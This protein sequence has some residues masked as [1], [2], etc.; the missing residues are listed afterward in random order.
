M[1]L[2]ALGVAFLLAAGAVQAQ[3][4]KGVSANG[5]GTAVGGTTNISITGGQGVGNNLFHSFT[6]FDLETGQSATFF[7]N[8]STANIIARVTGGPSWIDGT[9][10]TSA[11]PATSLW[12]LNPAG[13]AF[14]QN[15][16]LDVTGSFHASSA[17]AL[18][19]GASGQFDMASAPAGTLTV[20]PTA[21][22]FLSPPAPITVSG[23]QLTVPAGKHI[24][25]VGGDIT[26]NG[27]TLHVPA[28]QINVA[29]LA[30][31][32]EVTVGSGSMGAT[33][34]SS[35]GQ[36]TLA[37]SNLNTWDGSDPTLPG[38]NAG[39]IF[40]RGG[41]L[42]MDQAIVS[43]AHTAAG[44]GGDI[45]IVL[46]GDFSMS[47][48]SQINA[49]S[50]GSGNAGNITL[51]AGNVV[52]SGDQTR[53]DNSAVDQLGSSGGRAGQTIIEASGDMTL[54]GGA[55][56]TSVTFST[57][58]AGGDM[59]ITARNLT[60]S[61][62]LSMI[63]VATFGDGAGG[64][65]I[66]NVDSLRVAD[67]G[68]IA[69]ASAPHPT[70]GPAFGNAGSIDITAAHSVALT[71]GG[72]ITTFATD[73]G[74]G[75]ITIRATDLVSL[76]HSMITT[77][78]ADGTGNGG[79]ISIDPVFVTLNA[80][81]II[82]QTFNGQ[83]GHINIVT[84]FFIADPTSTV[85]ASAL[86]G[87]GIPGIVEISSPNVD[88]GSGLAVLPSGYF[89]ASALLR[90]SC[91]VRGARVASSFVGT[92]RGAL[93]AGPD[94]AGYARYALGPVPVVMAEVPLRVAQ[95]QQSVLLNCRG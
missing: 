33:G 18:K 72:Q 6:F 81:Q 91:A 27:A 16:S 80:S 31:A 84:Q 13:I 8:V 90:E 47:G 64:N 25:L 86:G 59:S 88:A 56:L 11:G 60:V 7:G 82:A 83:G 44:A 15:A 2:L 14:G 37:N 28:G 75:R 40:I 76:D 79:D 49:T 62:G 89:D 26:A 36:I 1:R 61:G 77:S 51:R 4:G 92:G 22:V 12:F 21:F 9:L 63:N 3:G 78:V 95:R 50:T 58:G 19:F 10:R 55:Q 68:R 43:T 42:T 73:A 53:I 35:Y 20:S 45:E 39:A 34:V 41:K 5:L 23:S 29:S 30:S 57:A 93:P 94:G 71:G 48:G 67:G 70:A 87:N 65:I 52:A 24:S 74:G 46:A 54:S 32:G 66:I 38:P 85:N 17:H 69:A